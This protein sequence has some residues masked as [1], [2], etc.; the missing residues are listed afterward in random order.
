MN[1]KIWKNDGH[2]LIYII[3]LMVIDILDYAFICI[4]LA[5]IILNI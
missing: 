1:S 2:S 4:K 3:S 5:I